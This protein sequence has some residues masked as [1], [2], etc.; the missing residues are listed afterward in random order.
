[1]AINCTVIN[2]FN[3]DLLVRFLAHIRGVCRLSEATASSYRYQLLGYL[4]RLESKALPLS[5]V[6]QET[7][8]SILAERENEGA[9][10]GTL[11]AFAMAVRRFH[12]YLC[13]IGSQY[14]DPTAHLKIPKPSQR[15]PH[16]LSTKEAEQ[17]LDLGPT[18]NVMRLR[19]RALFE[20]VYGSG[21]RASEA[22]G[23]T[24]AQIDLQR[25]TVR[26]LGKRNKE[27]MVPLSTTAVESL[28][29]YLVAKE[30]RFGWDTE[31]VFLNIKGR[32]LQR[33]GFSWLVRRRAEEARMHT[34]VTPH[35]FRHS[36]ATHLMEGGASLRAIQELLGHAH[37]T[38]TQIYTH[39]DLEFLTKTCKSAHPRF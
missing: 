33:G 4:S 5:R 25:R 16:H 39:V 3:S 30:L 35:V 6:S 37:I 27:R 34:R 13:G 18:D 31:V 28:R 32:P 20:L 26:V 10:P 15:I 21:L 9:A 36:Y 11:F 17:F 24:R 2:P 1:M 14:Q 29:C 22:V 8:V 38:T 7:L 23:I 12:R 19:D